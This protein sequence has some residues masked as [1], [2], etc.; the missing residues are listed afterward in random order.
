MKLVFFL[1]ILILNISL[2]EKEKRGQFFIQSY[3]T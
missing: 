2:N 1:F 3:S